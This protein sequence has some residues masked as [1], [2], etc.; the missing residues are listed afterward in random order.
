MSREGRIGLGESGRA[1]GGLATDGC[2]VYF[3]EGG[4]IRKYWLKSPPRGARRRPLQPSAALSFSI[5]R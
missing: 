2:R 4:A 3:T 1:A 5:F